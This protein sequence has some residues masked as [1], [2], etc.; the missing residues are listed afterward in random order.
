MPFQCFLSIDLP[1]A[2]KTAAGF[3]IVVTADGDIPFPQ[4]ILRQPGA[5]EWLIKDQRV[6]VGEEDYQYIFKVPADA[7]QAGITW[8]QIEGCKQADISNAGADDWVI[9]H[10]EIF[11]ERDAGAAQIAPQKPPGHV[12]IGATDEPVIYFGIHK[13]MHQPY[14]NVTDT[15]YWDGEKEHIFASRQGPYT[16]FIPAAVEQYIH[17]G[18]PHA[19]LSTSWS[20]SLIEQLDRCTKKDC[21]R[22]VFGN[23]NEGLRNMAQ[24]QTVLGNP[25]VNFTAFGMFH[26]LM[27]LIPGRDIIGQIRLHRDIIH[28]IFAAKAGDMLFPPET[29]FA[30]HM[31]PA[32]KAAGINSVIFDSVHLFRASKNY[33]YSGAG[34]GLLPPNKAE[35]VNPPQN[36]WLQLNGVWAP[37]K[38]S[39]SLLKPCLLVYTDRQDKQHAITGIPAERYLGNE[40]ARGGYG[41]LQYEIVMGQLLEQIKATGSFD[42]QHPPFF[43]LHSDGDNH[44]G[45]AE[46]YY[47]SNTGRLVEMCRSDSR[48]Q[49]VTADDYLQQFPVDPH[50][51]VHVEAGS[52]AGADNGDAQFSKWFSWADKDYSP[53]LNS[54]AV[55]TALQ[56]LVHSLE[57]SEQDKHLLRELQ[58]LL[59]MAETSCYWY[60][61]GQ[62]VW[63]AQVSNA[64]KKALQMVGGLFEKVKN[65]DKTAPT[66]FLPWVRPA[67]PGGQ[68][69]GN[70]GLVDAAQEATIKTFVYDLNGVTKVSLH[71]QAATKTWK[72]TT[73]NDAGAYPSRTNSPLVAN[74]YQTV[75][76]PGSG[77]VRYYV[78]AI[79]GKGNVAESPVQ[80]VF[81]A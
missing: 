22:G 8:L 59:Y 68:D 3:D 42:P 39:P 53:D 21:A 33:P 18:L 49:L 78:S 44:G 14:Y 65:A 71:Y 13:H 51:K 52:W 47:T 31:I 1:D 77:D 61:T 63:D 73:M 69:W 37:G 6:E 30:P 54:W 25:R 5:W 57:D 80:R 70:S 67:N 45:G 15:D 26:P 74:L 48:F 4:L 2:V 46:S 27:P 60:W 24:A 36:D 75:L 11:I 38:V 7:Y 81:V 50:N 16:R 79:D 9:E 41:A 28:E 32:L 23:W 58:R 19:G 35:Q 17:G 12:T 40:D 66:I 62:D 43:L 64:A 34:E 56:N 55:L 76:P 10:R 29:A 72:K 20:G